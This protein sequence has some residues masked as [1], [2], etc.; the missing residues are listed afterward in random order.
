MHTASAMVS[1]T[2]ENHA[3][4]DPVLCRCL[5]QRVLTQ[6]L[7]CTAPILRIFQK[8]KTR[9]KQLFSRDWIMIE[10][11]SAFDEKTVQLW[12]YELNCITLGLWWHTFRM[13][14]MTIGGNKDKGVD[15]SVVLKLRICPFRNDL[16][17]AIHENV[18]TYIPLFC[19]LMTHFFSSVLMLLILFI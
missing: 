14:F 2:R 11:Y 10:S 17:Q 3:L 16:S 6:L 15:M 9:K 18:H 8:K 19:L 12:H 5:R 1:I 13:Y 7:F 4:L